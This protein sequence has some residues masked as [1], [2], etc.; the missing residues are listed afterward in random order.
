MVARRTVLQFV[1]GVLFTTGVPTAAQQGPSRVVWF[2]P[3]RREEGATFFEALRS[4]LREL[5]YVEGGNLALEARW[6]D[7]TRPRADAIATELAV[8]K[9]DVIVAQGTTVYAVR[10]AGIRAPVV[11]AFS[12]DP[13]EA[14]LVRAFSRPEGN[15]TGIS[16]LALE[17]AGKRIELLKTVAPAI[18]RIAVV[19]N[20]QH[21]GDQ[22]ERRVSATAAAALGLD[23]DDFESGSTAQLESS[24]ADIVKARCEAAV[25][26]PVQS[27]ISNSGRIAAWSIRH[28]I[29]TISGWAPFADQGNLLSYGCNLQEAFRRLATFVDR[30]LKGSP[31]G[32]LPVELPLQIELVVNLKTARALGTAVPRSVMLRADRVIE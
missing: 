15:L 25:L 27:V 10:N 5:G 12:G 30:I 11:F 31:P 3:G 21:P 2:S 24:L 28:R 32:A 22:A 23:I 18:R 9:P 1:G 6:A 29:P 19:A 14:G 26:F 4:G 20:S 13:V 7:N 8:G 17:L 16:F